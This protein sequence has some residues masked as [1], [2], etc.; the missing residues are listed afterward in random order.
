MLFHQPSRV[1]DA[2][3]LHELV[4]AGRIR[5]VVSTAVPEPTLLEQVGDELAGLLT[6]ARVGRPVDSR[7]RLVVRSSPV[8]RVGSL[9]ADQCD[10]RPYQEILTGCKN[11]VDRLRDLGLLP[12]VD[13]DRANAYLALHESPWPNPP[14]IQADAVLYFDDLT[15][16]YFTHLGIL[17]VVTSA[18]FTVFVSDLALKRTSELIAYDHASTE[19]ADVIESITAVLSRK[20][21]EGGLQVV[22]TDRG[23]E[24]DDGPMMGHP[25]LA[26]PALGAPCESIVTDDRFFN[27][28]PRYEAGEDR[29]RVHTTVDLLDA[30]ERRG[31]LSA[32]EKW[33][34]LTRLRTAQYLF[35]PVE[36]EEVL[37]YL[38]AS[39][40]LDDGSLQ[41][42][43]ELR[44]LREN[45][46]CA[47]MS[48]HLHGE[49][50]PWLRRTLAAFGMALK[51]LWTSGI[52]AEE[53]RARSNWVW[54]QIDCR[55]WSHCFQSVG[56]DA[57]R[58]ALSLLLAVLAF[59]PAEASEDSRRAYEEWLNVT[60]FEPVRL[61]DPDLY[62]WVV[63][64]HRRG[65]EE[66]VMKHLSEGR[67][68]AE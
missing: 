18:G 45:L 28:Y 52:S 43:L 8:Y 55:L 1:K 49:D 10:L 37:Q 51:R 58:H 47:R 66:I 12:A 56:P 15:I 20:L 61:G 29:A 2:R 27:R 42:S 4:S 54:E 11:V 62:D 35:V 5:S 19:V 68:D 34:Y 31:L 67:E 13:A 30:L 32:Q 22:P 14:T 57:A 7:Q 50:T 24:V 25:S 36:P 38:L 9:M 63:E 41:E 48:N 3:R 53:A 17:D 60:C 46:L 33:A 23:F 6:D 65:I 26:L 21:A 16:V 64:L 59:L 44:A 40:V 39:T